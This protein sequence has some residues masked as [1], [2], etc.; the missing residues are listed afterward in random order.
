MLRN[1]H[2]LVG[3]G[4][5]GGGFRSTDKGATWQALPFL[6][7]L[8]VVEAGGGRLIRS[9]SGSKFEVST[10]EGVTWT[11]LVSSG[12]PDIAVPLPAV[13]TADGAGHLFLFGPDASSDASHLGPRQVFAS[14]DGGVHFLPMRAQ[15]LNPYPTSFAADKKGR[16]LVGTLAGVF[17]LE[18]SVDPGP[19]QPDGG[20]TDPPD[21]GGGPSPRSLSL[22][23]G[24]GPWF[25]DAVGLAV[26][27]AHRVYATDNSTVYVV[28]AAGTISPYLTQAEAAS[29]AGVDRYPSRSSTSTWGRTASSTSCCPTAFSASRPARTGS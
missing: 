15:I 26:D 6:S 7:A 25:P 5:A 27:A 19:P 13:V 28:D 4:S 11:P 20:T 1:G 17:R 10:D 9:V 2:L 21:G 24:D 29:A 18:S 16:L 14:T 8:P 23:T 22:V 12:V 3:R